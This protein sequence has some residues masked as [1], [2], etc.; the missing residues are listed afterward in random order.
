MG[1]LEKEFDTKLQLERIQ[2]ERKKLEREMQMKNLEMQR[3]L[4]ERERELER[5]LQITTLEKDDILSQ[6]TKA[7][8]NSPF[9]WISKKRDVSEW[10][11]KLSETQTPTRPKTRFDVS[12]ERSEDRHYSR[13]L[14]SRDRSA[15]VEDRDVLHRVSMRTNIGHSSG[16]SLPKLK[17]NKSDGNPLEWPE[18]GLACLS[19]Q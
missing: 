15:S 1:D 19:Q 12:L 4:R 9:N 3:Q 6:S 7:R 18:C 8:D 10:A 2:F 5:K 11:N 17:L 16:S 14:N 13:Y